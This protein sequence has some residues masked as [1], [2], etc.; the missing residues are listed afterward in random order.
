MFV[1]VIPEPIIEE[2]SFLIILPI[3]LS[4]ASTR[5]LL[6]N[7]LG[8]AFCNSFLNEFATEFIIIDGGNLL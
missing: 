2:I 3:I 5:R 8:P 1:R 4:P 6:F 7:S